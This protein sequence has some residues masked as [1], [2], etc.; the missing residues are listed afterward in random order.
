MNYDEAKLKNE[1]RTIL[2]NKVRI[3]GIVADI[4]FLIEKAVEEEIKDYKELKGISD[5]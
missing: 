4:L 3:K 2:D 5:E 1:I